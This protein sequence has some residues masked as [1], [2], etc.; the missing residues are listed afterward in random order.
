MFKADGLQSAGGC[1]QQIPEARKS[2]MIIVFFIDFP[3]E[4][5]FKNAHSWFLDETSNSTHYKFA[6]KI[7]LAKYAEPIVR[8]TTSGPQIGHSHWQGD[9]KQRFLLKN[10]MT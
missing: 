8:L 4:G 6:L 2:N 10:G 3:L 7:N 1:A 9:W 5:A